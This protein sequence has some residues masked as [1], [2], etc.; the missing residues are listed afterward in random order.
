[1]TISQ[2]SLYVSGWKAEEKLLPCFHTCKVGAEAGGMDGTRAHCQLS[3]GSSPW[4][5]ATASP[6]AA[7]PPPGS[8]SPFPT[9]GTGQY[10]AP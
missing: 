3:T 2:N 10:L 6:A 9:P 7:L 8:S 4:R 1:M 5:G